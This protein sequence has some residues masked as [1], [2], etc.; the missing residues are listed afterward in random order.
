MRPC[1]CLV[2]FL[3][4]VLTNECRWGRSA[5]RTAV[6]Q[7]GELGVVCLDRGQ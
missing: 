5:A 1:I 4:R 2:I 6:I 7:W 3:V